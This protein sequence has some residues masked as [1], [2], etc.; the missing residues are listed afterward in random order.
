M[1]K[2]FKLIF[3]KF[4]KAD[5]SRSLDSSG[6]GLGLYL[7]NSIINMHNGKIK[8]DSIEGLFTEF[9]FTIRANNN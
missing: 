3:D 9:V 8:V 5:Q 1:Q 7:S 2:E 4:Y 6:L